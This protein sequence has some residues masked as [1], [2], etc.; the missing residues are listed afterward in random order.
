MLVKR[1]RGHPVIDPGK[2]YSGGP[3]ETAH[4]LLIWRDKSMIYYLVGDS[5]E[6]LHEVANQLMRG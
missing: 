2:V 3:N 6:H 4:P 1:Y 5:E